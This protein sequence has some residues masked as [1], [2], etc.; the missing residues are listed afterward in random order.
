MKKTVLVL[1]AMALVSAGASA[2]AVY[3]CLPS[4]S[5]GTYVPLE[6]GT[7]IYDGA[8][9]SEDIKGDNLEGKVFNPEGVVTADQTNVKGWDIGFNYRFAGKKVSQFVVSGSGFVAFGDTEVS[10]TPDTRVFYEDSNML[11]AGCTPQRGLSGLDN[12]K[13]SYGVEGSD[14]E[15]TLVV[16]YE[17]YGVYTSFFGD[18]SPI[19]MQLRFMEDGSWSVVFSGLSA[20]EDMNGKFYCGMCAENNH[21]YIDDTIQ[22]FV[23]NRRS[24]GLL[25]V[26][27]TT[28]DGYTVTF[29]APIDCKIPAAGPSDLILT[30]TS[31]SV[32]G[33]FTGT[34]SADTY[35]VVYSKNATE[36]NPVDGTYYEA[37]SVVE[38]V[39]ISYFGFETEFEDVNLDGGENLYYKVYAVSSYG[40]N[41]PIYNMTDVLTGSTATLPSG[42]QAELK[43]VGLDTAVL[44]VTGNNKGDNV[45]V[46][47]TDYCFRDRFGDK[48]LF[49]RLSGNLAVGDT[50]AIPEDY[51]AEYPVD[52]MPAPLNGGVVAYAGPAGEVE[53]KGLKPSTLYFYAV[54]SYDANNNYSSDAV[55]GEVFTVIEAPYDGNT[56][57][58]PRYTLPQGWSTNDG[59]VNFRDDAYYDRSE[60]KPSQGTQIIQQNARVNRGSADGVTTWLATSPI[61]ITDRHIMAKYD[62]CM[63]ESPNRFSTNAYNKWAENDSL[64]IQVSEDNGLNWNTLA[65]Y[66]ENDHPQQ[67]TIYSYVSIEADLN[68]YRDKT[69]LLR[70]AWTTH[71]LSPFGTNIY[72]D[73]ISLQKGDFPDVPEVSVG[74]VTYD[75]A[76]LTWKSTQN[77]YEVAYR[78]ESEEEYT[79]LKVTG[80]TTITLKDLIPETKYVA[81]VRGILADN[82]YSEWSDSVTFTTA[83]WPEVEPPTDLA[84]GM[85]DFQKTQSAKLTWKATEDMESFEIA[86]RIGSSTEWIYKTSDKPELIIDGLEFST[87]YIWKVRAFCSHDRETNYSYQANFTTPDK[88]SGISEILKG[89]GNIDIY[90]IEGTKVNVNNGVLEPGVYVIKTETETRRIL[91][92]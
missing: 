10:V 68:A 60:S 58:F 7:V 64:L 49:G 76:V 89:A 5:G 19:N 29:A 13:I 85:E 31:T 53:L 54:Y 51:E 81:K 32:S 26:P 57:N 25:D 41:G 38:D 59:M 48:G 90:S 86:Y 44:T 46:L 77:D 62:Y 37:G 78:A 71:S 2:Q 74:T 28:P 33:S 16:Q 43:S 30:S 21:I 11:A 55:D 40:L 18:P 15:K 84:S 36:W 24:S 22:E 66:D 6:N 47:L 14:I 75:T 20:F 61:K 87:R 1:V 92:K 9:A 3:G 34:D 12:T 69:I 45:M 79:T 4:G 83:D 8:S 72:V 80:A 88:E 23:V 27:S 82:Q 63:T 39:T 42:P 91:V 65:K 73:R 35:L 52:V 17:N 67:D 56:D 70:L 50:L